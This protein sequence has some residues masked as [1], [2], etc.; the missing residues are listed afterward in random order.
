[1][2]GIV[3][4]LARSERLRKSLGELVVPMLTCMGERGPDSAGLALFSEPVGGGLRRFNL[5]APDRSFDWHK[6]SSHFSADAGVAGTIEAVENHA[7]LI[8]A[9]PPGIFSGWLKDQY[10]LVHLLSVGRAIN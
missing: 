2:C 7:V 6:L 3:G 10:S 4:F 9:V 5:F 8:S 1:M